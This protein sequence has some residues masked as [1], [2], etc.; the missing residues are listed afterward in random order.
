MSTNSKLRT[1]AT[2][3]PPLQ[4]L[5]RAGNPLYNAK[6][7]H[8]S[9]ILSHNPKAQDKEGNP[10]IADKYYETSSPKLVDHFAKLKAAFVL[11]GAK[12][13]Q[14]YLDSVIAIVNKRMEAVTK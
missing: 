8:G 7:I 13:V 4:E 12:G 9:S 5:D 2:Q 14:A 6:R 10:I 11:N 1:L 3:L